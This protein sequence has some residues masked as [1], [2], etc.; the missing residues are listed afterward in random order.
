MLEHSGKQLLLREDKD[1]ICTLTLNR[2][3]TRNALSSELLSELQKTF[4]I[5][6]SD[7]KIKVIIIAGNGSMFSSGHDLKEIRKNSSYNKM[8]TLFNQCGK[9]MITMKQQ[10]QPI[11]AKVHGDALAAG[12]Q[13]VCNC[14]LA[15]S[16]KTSK[17]ALPGSSIGLFC[18]SPA[19][20]VSRAAN[21]KQTME[22]LLLGEPFNANDAERFGLINKA[23]AGEQLDE[24]VETY[25]NKIV[26]H[27]SL[28][29][30]MGKNAFYKQMDM[31]LESAY[32]FTSEIM[33]KNMQ[34]QDAH[35]GID[36]F[37]EKRTPNWRGR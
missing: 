6:A 37:L 20:A 31:D 24:T 18:S 13:L 7:K 19:V 27:S 5:I 25:A 1:G 35:E 4:N 21:S 28:T 26:K 10:P 30:S 12:C 32:A 36:A 11:I 17:F 15:I 14:D 29:I 9:M 34:E 33:A 3:D 2:P 8:L 16:A 22:M 23:V